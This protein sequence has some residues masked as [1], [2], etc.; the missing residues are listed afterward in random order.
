MFIDQKI[1]V[2]RHFRGVR[3]REQQCAIAHPRISRF[4]VRC[5]ASP[6]NDARTIRTTRQKEG[7]LKAGL[8]FDP[9]ILKSGN[10][11]VLV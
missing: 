11:A 7:P 3:E 9:L 1:A 10:Q 4:R 6:R 2:F 8:A 5:F